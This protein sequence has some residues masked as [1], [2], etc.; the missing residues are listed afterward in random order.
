MLGESMCESRF[1][2]LL[3]FVLLPLF[4]KERLEALQDA[5]VVGK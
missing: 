4:L 1:M 3:F 2:S 5:V